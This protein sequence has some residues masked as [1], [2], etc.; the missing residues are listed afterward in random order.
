MPDNVQREIIV[1]QAHELFLANGY[2]GTT[3]D[4]IAASCRVSKRTLYRLFPGK[5]DLFAA[6]IDKN[7]QRMLLLPGNY[8]DMPLDEA[9]ETIFRVEI[10]P[11]DNRKRQALIRLVIIET[12]QYP[13]LRTTARKYGAI[14]SRLELAAWFD[15]Q[16]AR[17]RMVIDDTEAAAQM[18]LDMVFG[19]IAAKA[20]GGDLDWPGEDDREGYIKRC[21][22]VFLHGVQKRDGV[23]A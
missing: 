5:L 4:H 3:M 19:A 21:I 8:D 13:E 18:L 9:L 14:P 16:C 23:P 11:E 22:Q 6:I 7:R 1:E 12:R 10:D 15:R 17:G 20:T 2:G